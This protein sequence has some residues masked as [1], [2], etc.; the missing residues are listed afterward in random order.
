MNNLFRYSNIIMNDFLSSTNE[1]MDEH[2]YRQ[3]F[4]GTEF[5]DNFISLSEILFPKYLWCFYMSCPQLIIFGICS[6]KPS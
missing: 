1:I 5:F 2:F 6:I 3:E 4:I